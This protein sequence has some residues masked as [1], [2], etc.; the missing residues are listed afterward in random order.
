MFVRCECCVFSGIGLCG[1]LITRPEDSYRVWGVV[2]CDQETWTD[3]EAKARYRAV[4]NTTTKG[5]NARKTNKRTITYLKPSM[6]LGYI[7]SQLFRCKTS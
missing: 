3:E 6:F 1:R 2:V 7:V 5:C 4:E